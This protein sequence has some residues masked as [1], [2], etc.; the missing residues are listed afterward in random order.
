MVFQFH[1]ID[2][3]QF[4]I[5]CELIHPFCK[6]IHLWLILLVLNKVGYQSSVALLRYLGHHLFNSSQNIVWLIIRVVALLVLVPVSLSWTRLNYHWWSVGIILKHFGGVATIPC[7]V[8]SSLKVCLLRCPTKSDSFP[9]IFIDIEKRQKFFIIDN[10]INC[11][12][13]HV[14]QLE[15]GFY[16]L[17]LG[18][19]RYHNFTFL[20]P[21]NVP[22]AF[23]PLNGVFFR[24][25][26][27]SV[28]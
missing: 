24:N 25:V 11:F 27:H 5:H 15:S 28:F 18:F 14:M 9:K 8:K 3:D 7:E 21:V 2:V 19:L 17:S 12:K 13:G 20:I 22:L 10:R 1:T 16:H 6:E 4:C 23:T 26:L